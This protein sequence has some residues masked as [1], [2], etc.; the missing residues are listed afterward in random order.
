MKSPTAE[1][2]FKLLQALESLLQ[3]DELQRADVSDDTRELME[4]VLETAA[5]VRRECEFPA[6]EEIIA[7]FAKRFNG[8]DRERVVKRIVA[9][10]TTLSDEE[11]YSGY[12][13]ALDHDGA[14]QP[15]PT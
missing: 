10:V 15:R 7:F 1:S 8:E 12:E 9:L 11:L 3:C 4:G 13:E 14:G 2:A 6:R 5:Q